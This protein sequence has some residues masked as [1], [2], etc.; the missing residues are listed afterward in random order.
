MRHRMA[1][2]HSPPH[3][4]VI[5]DDE[6]VFDVRGDPYGPGSA[7]LPPLPRRSG[8]RKLTRA[9]SVIWRATERHTIRL[10]VIP[11]MASTTAS[12]RSGAGPA[13]ATVRVPPE[14]G[15][16]CASETDRWGCRR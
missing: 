1:R 12:D 13:C 11:W 10:L 9:A 4:E 6:H 5:E 3:F 16:V 15:T 2:E 14:T 7:A 8:A